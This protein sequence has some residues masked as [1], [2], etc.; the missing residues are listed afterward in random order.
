[1]GS[2]P[3]RRWWRRARPARS[4]AARARRVQG[5]RRRSGRAR[6]RSRSRPGPPPA[7]AERETDASP[8]HHP[9]G[10]G[11]IRHLTQIGSRGSRLICSQAKRP[12]RSRWPRRAASSGTNKGTCASTP[13]RRFAV[14]PVATEM[15]IVSP[16]RISTR[17]TTSV[18]ATSGRARS[19]RW[20]P[21]GAV[22]VTNSSPGPAYGTGMFSRGRSPGGRGRAAIAER[23]PQRVRTGGVGQIELRRSIPPAAA[24]GGGV[25][26]DGE[27]SVERLG[28][29]QRNI[30]G[31]SRRAGMARGPAAAPRGDRSERRKARRAV[32]GRP[33]GRPLPAR[34]C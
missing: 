4:A 22:S 3:V 34:I 25:K 18:Q 7:R 10:D 26:R 24:P 19:R 17:E 27:I 5:M 15:T 13:G 28:A 23:E 8:G 30:L 29:R 2:G 31:V 16:E 12:L 20:M 14:S 32:A 33:S 11:S 21:S 6:T 9:E 1:M